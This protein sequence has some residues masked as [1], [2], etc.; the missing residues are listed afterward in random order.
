[1]PFRILQ[2]RPRNRTQCSKK[3]S[4]VR[5]W[6]VCET[7]LFRPPYW[8]HHFEFCKF[9]LKIVLSARK[10]PKVRYSIDY[11]NI[12]TLAAILHLPARILK[13][14]LEID[15]QR[16]KKTPLV[17]YWLVCGTCRLWLSFWILHFWPR[18]RTLRPKKPL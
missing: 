3:P 5:Y 10:N 12:K 13:F 9:D 7:L 14:D 18:I 8:I 1:M 16:P 11:P 4:W 15:T 2:V 6:L 17:W